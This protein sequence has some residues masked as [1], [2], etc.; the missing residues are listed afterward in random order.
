MTQPTPGDSG[1]MGI[2]GFPNLGRLAAR[3]NRLA[4]VISAFAFAFSAVSFYETVLKQPNIGIHVPAVIHYARDGGGD[5]ELFAVPLTITNEGARSG[6]VLGIELTVEN[7]K[8]EGDAQKQKSYYSA[9]LGEHPRDSAALNSAF[10]PITVAGRASYSGTIRFYP[11]GNPLPRLVTENG[12]YKFT[13][14]VRT[15]APVTNSLVD[16]IFRIGDPPPIAFER[17]MPYLSEQYLN[18]RRGSIAMHSKDWK[19]TVT[20]QT[21]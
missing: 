15:A 8:A 21:R 13:L 9:Y 18:F 2:S 10:A 11:Q 20:T 16:R 5:V 17:T 3:G 4:T 14:T 19:P 1:L 6:T 12:D 7:P